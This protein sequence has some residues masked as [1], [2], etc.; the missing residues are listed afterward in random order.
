MELGLV[1]SLETARQ[2]LNRKE[3]VSKSKNVNLVAYLEF[4][5]IANCRILL[6]GFKTIS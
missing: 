2:L 1:E 5:E 6:V 4:F 3:T